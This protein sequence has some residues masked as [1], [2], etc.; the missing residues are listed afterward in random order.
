MKN[1]LYRVRQFWQALTARPSAADLQEIQALLSPAQ[2][3]LFSRLQPSEQAHAIA[4]FRKIRRQDSNP[5]LLVAA[6]LHDIGKIMYPLSLW[7]RVL[8]VLRGNGLP[9]NGT[10]KRPE[11]RAP[12]RIVAEQHPNWGADLASKAGASALAAALIRRHQDPGPH[13]GRSSEDRLL[14]VL[15]AADNE[16]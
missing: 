8:V 9:E 4:V 12:Y 14:A 15:Q 10:K 5:D 2:F 16:S 11:R 7:E 3:L 1:S 13:N 6:L